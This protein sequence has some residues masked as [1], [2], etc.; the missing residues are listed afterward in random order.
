M[1]E[2]DVMEKFKN[3]FYIP[4]IWHSTLIVSAQGYVCKPHKSHTQDV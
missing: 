4:C 1:K 2:M 3:C